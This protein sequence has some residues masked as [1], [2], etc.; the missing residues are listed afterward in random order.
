MFFV[1]FL[2]ALLYVYRYFRKVGAS[3]A[4]RF[5]ERGSGR[6]EVKNSWG[7]ASFVQRLFID[8]DGASLDRAALWDGTQRVSYR[9]LRERLLAAALGLNQLG[10]TKIRL[11]AERKGV[12]W[13]I[14]ELALPLSNV[15]KSEDATAPVLSEQMIRTWFDDISAVLDVSS[16]KSIVVE[17][18]FDGLALTEGDSVRVSLGGSGS[19]MRL[20]ALQWQLASGMGP[21]VLSDSMPSSEGTVLVAT[22]AEVRAALDAIASELNAGWFLRRWA[23]RQAEGAA[24]AMRGSWLS[25][26]MFDMKMVRRNWF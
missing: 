1:V 20:R 5:V 13:A 19:L 4:S 18:I 25:R 24:E 6:V 15:E 22:A 16:L 11:P 23:L 9:Q 12:E 14:V 3:V 17:R 7:S 26:V 8:I 21:S 2:A 10:T